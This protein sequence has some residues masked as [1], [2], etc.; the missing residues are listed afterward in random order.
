MMSLNRTLFGR[1][2]RLEEIRLEHR[3]LF[4]AGWFFSAESLLLL[5]LQDLGPT[6]ATVPLYVRW[7]EALR[8]LAIFVTNSVRDLIPQYRFLDQACF[9]KWFKIDFW[10]S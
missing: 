8:S 10:P 4:Q 2:I 1:L 5:Q 3:E 6:R 9:K 7:N